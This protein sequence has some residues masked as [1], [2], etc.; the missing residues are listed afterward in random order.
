MVKVKYF[1]YEFDNGYYFDYTL[2][3]LKHTDIMFRYKTTSKLYDIFN[4]QKKFREIKLVEEKDL[5]TP[6]DIR[7][8][9]KKIL[10]KLDIPNNKLIIP[11]KNYLF[12]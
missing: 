4:N 8:E 6:R 12:L 3:D 1:I 5:E 7:L 9:G 10:R 11:S 2:D